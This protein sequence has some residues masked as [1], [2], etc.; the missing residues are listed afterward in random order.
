MKRILLI[1]LLLVGMSAGSTTTSAINPKKRVVCIGNSITY[2][3][4]LKNREDAYPFVL[5]RLLGDG[6]EVVNIGK[7][8]AQLMGNPYI[9]PHTDEHHRLVGSNPDVIIVKLGTNDSRNDAKRT[10][11]ELEVAFYRDYCQLI[12]SLKTLT[13]TIFVC[14]PIYPY[15][16]KWTARNRTLRKIIRPVI[17]RVAK[18]KGISVI[19]LYK[20][21]KPKDS[22]YKPDGIHPTEEGH[23]AMAVCVY[24]A[25]MKK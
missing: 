24:H 3:V 20:A 15:G 22:L 8:G 9:K 7:P 6:Y 2:G 19:D 13:P 25:I 5:Q 11:K 21:I 18:E 1:G 10:K 23:K 4:L 16:E 17:K 12:D 14:V